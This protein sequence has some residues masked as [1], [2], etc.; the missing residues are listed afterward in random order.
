M[1]KSKLKNIKNNSNY[2]RR[3]LKFWKINLSIHAT[4]NNIKTIYTKI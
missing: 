2:G 4:A 3:N 1:R